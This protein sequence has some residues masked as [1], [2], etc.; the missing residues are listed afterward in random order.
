MVA[1]FTYGFD[2]AKRN[3][4]EN[5]CDLVTLSDYDSMLTA[6]VSANYVSETDTAS[7]SEWRKSPHTW[8]PSK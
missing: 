5:K 7:L 6:A 4:E 3:F 2:L 1:I 8:A